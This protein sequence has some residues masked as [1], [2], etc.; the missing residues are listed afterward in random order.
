[1]K[2]NSPERHENQVL[3]ILPVAQ[4]QNFVLDSVNLPWAIDYPGYRPHFER[5]LRRWSSLFS[6]KTEDDQGKLRINEI[7]KDRLAGFALHLGVILRRIWSERDGRQRD[8]YFYR[9]RDSFHQMIVRLENPHLIE[10]GDRDIVANLIQLERL[11]HERGDNSSQRARVFQNATGAHLLEDVPKLCPFEA[12]IYW[13]Q[14]NQRLMLYCEGPTCPAPYFLRTEKGQKF[15][16][17]ECANP[18]RREAKRRWW[19]E[20]RGKYTA[21][22]T[23]I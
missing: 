21:K 23:R 13:L 1:M 18:A 14:L 10:I 2:T 8:W 9:L 5:W 12:S 15:C 3:G 4:V 17:P 16:K 22:K 19:H 7:P 20:N 11:S 6:F